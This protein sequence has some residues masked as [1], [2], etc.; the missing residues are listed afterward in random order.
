M[1]LTVWRHGEAGMAPIDQSR[2]LTARGISDVQTGAAA[3]AEMLELRALSAPSRL[4]FS[5]WQRT[6]ETAD[7]IAR[8]FPH[9]P[10]QPLDA[11]IPGSTVEAALSSLQDLPDLGEH[12]LIV[13]HQPLVSR[14]VDTLLGERGR[15]PPLAPGSFACIEFDG[16][17]AP[18]CGLLRYWAAPPDY[19]CE[20]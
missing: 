8:V 2:T 14:L 1:L 7:L 17:P 3:F 16:L 13:S 20:Y 5:R 12:V 9:L 18:G 15:V 10:T 4:Y 11:L 6:R 19:S